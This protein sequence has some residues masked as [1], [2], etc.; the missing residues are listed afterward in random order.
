MVT[1]LEEEVIF[2]K[3]DFHYLVSNH[4]YRHHRP[5]QDD[6]DGDYQSISTL[7][8]VVQSV[9]QCKGRSGSI[10]RKWKFSMIK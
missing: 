10:Y 7:E 6:N 3:S 8:E 9:L 2:K 1:L 5:G 4:H